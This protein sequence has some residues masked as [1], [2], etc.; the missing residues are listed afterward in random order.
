MRIVGCSNRLVDASICQTAFER[1]SLVAR[2]RSH[3]R[4]RTRPRTRIFFRVFV[5]SIAL[6][7]DNK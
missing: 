1:T 2:N 7:P 5:Q 6:F 4:T 3:N